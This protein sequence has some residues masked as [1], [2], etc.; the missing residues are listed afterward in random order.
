MIS[1][2]LCCIKS[3]PRVEGRARTKKMGPVWKPLQR[4]KESMNC[5]EMVVNTEQRRNSTSTIKKKLP[6]NEDVVPFRSQA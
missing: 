4:L 5:Q 1:E 3:R 2:I 6:M